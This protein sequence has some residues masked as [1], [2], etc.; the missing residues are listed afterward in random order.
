MI[1]IK[2][3]SLVSTLSVPSSNR[4]GRKKTGMEGV[5]IEKKR[6]S[7]KKNEGKK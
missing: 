7:E 6:G 2:P 1:K 3:D 4:G 5:K